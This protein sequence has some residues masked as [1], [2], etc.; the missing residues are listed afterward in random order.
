MTLGPYLLFAA[1]LLLPEA[2]MQPPAWSIIDFPFGLRLGGQLNG[3]ID[4]ISGCRQ[5]P[6]PRRYQLAERTWN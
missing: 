4:G 2:G 3:V 1:W 5:W 6:R